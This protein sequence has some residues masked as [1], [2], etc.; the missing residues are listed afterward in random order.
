MEHAMVIVS[1]CE[2]VYW[3]INTQVYFISHRHNELQKLS[4]LLVVCDPKFKFHS[5]LIHA[6]I[7]STKKVNFQHCEV[8]IIPNLHSIIRS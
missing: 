1:R 7:L 8:Y 2:G 5:S 3:I 4:R 6:L